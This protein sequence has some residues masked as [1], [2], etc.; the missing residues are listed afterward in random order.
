M[1]IHSSTCALL[2]TFAA[3]ALPRPARAQ[4]LTGAIDIHAH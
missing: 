1:Q 4:T 3:F 2:L